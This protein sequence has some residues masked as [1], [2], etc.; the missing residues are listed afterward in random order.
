MTSR[1]IRFGLHVFDMHIDT[2]CAIILY[3]RKIGK[4]E[5]QKKLHTVCKSNRKK[6]VSTFPIIILNIRI[7]ILKW[8]FFE[9]IE[10]S[11]RVCHD[12]Y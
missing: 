4:Y 11:R 10:K 7:C 9:K 1:C 5:N 8:G 12:N 2:I 3:N 6:F